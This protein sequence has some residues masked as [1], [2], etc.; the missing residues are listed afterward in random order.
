MSTTSVAFF[1]DGAC[2][3]GLLTLP[4]RTPAAGVVLAHGYCNDKHEFGGFD[5]AAA[6]LAEAGY[7]VLRFD[8]RGCG[9]SD[10]I[11]GRMLVSSEWPADLRSAITY[12]RSRAEVDAERIGVVGQS[13]GGGM[14]ALAAAIDPRIRCAVSWAGVSNGERWQRDLWMTRHGEQGWRAFLA[15][16]EADR[17]RRVAT[18][19]SECRS[20]AETLAQ[21]TEETAFLDEM[22]GRFPAFRNVITLES[23]DSTLAFRPVDALAH[24]LCP[25][26]FIHGTADALVPADHAV[27]MR[28]QAGALADLALIEGA[29]HDLPIGD[30]KSEVHAL[31][32]AW[33]ARHLAAGKGALS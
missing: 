26:L 23:A 30:Y 27:A 32:L 4:A 11:P 10:G 6:V 14:V 15:Q 18:G 29:G 28:Q 9:E 8:F 16:I 22:T 12:L 5:A 24:C 31:T 25:I 1:S 13:M 17:V 19:A 21:N 2:I 7:A 33:L 20:L 3:S